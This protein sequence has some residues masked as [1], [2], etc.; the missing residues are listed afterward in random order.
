MAVG[1]SDDIEPSRAIKTVI[2]QCD[3][4]LDGERPIAGLLFAN[5]DIDP[6]PLLSAVK[7]AYPDVD[8]IGST[9]VGE[10]SSVMGFQDDSV[11]LAM[12]TAQRVDIT[13]GWATGISSDPEGATRR[14]V[15]DARAKTDKTPRLCLA[16]PSVALDEPSVVLHELRRALGDDVTVLGGGSGPRIVGDATLARQFYGDRVHDDAIAILLFSGPVLHSFGVDTGWR[17][18]G[19]TGT[20]TDAEGSS[21]QTIDGEPAVAFYEHYLGGGAKPSAGNPLAV[22]EDESDDFYLRVPL[23]FDA[24]TGTI[25]MA[26][27][28]TTGARVRLTVAVTEEIF[29][30]TRSAVRKAIEGYPPASAPE[31]ALVFSCAVRKLVLGT[32][33]GTEL[34]ITRR[35]LGPDMPVCGLYCYG[36]IAPIRT[37]PAR[38]H[39]E[40]IVA[41]L[42]GEAR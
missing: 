9:S 28:V 40:T 12:F 20:V 5:Y 26:G 19:R 33:T 11:A 34:D 21:I 3:R 31:A 39:N 24:A 35:E 8:V 23:R 1:H 13:A 16:F 37:G 32:R 29:D 14:A 38:F 25:E 36:E 22:F 18:V 17:A 27:R 42:L 41:V 15:G 7:A 2:A 10:M 30:G 4:A 6:L